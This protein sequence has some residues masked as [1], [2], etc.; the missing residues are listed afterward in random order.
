MKSKSILSVKNLKISF[1]SGKEENIAVDGVSF[2]LRKGEILGIVGES[3]SGKSLTS[4]SILGLTPPSGKLESTEII[5]DDLDIRTKLNDLNEKEF[6][7]IRGNR[8][9]MIFQEPSSSLNP[10]YT[11]GNQVREMFTTHKK[12]SRKEAKKRTLELFEKVNL[13]NS[14]KIYHSYPHE[15]SGGQMQ[16]VMI[17]MA[18]ACQPAILLAD[19]PTTALDVTI[20]KN[21]LELMDEMRKEMGTSIIF[22]SHDLGV[23]AEIADRVLVMYKGKIVE[24]G[25]IEEIFVRPQH[26]YTKGLL[27]CR[28]RLDV[29]L[30]VLPTIEDFMAENESEGGERKFR[31]VGEALILNAETKGELIQKR[32]DTIKGGPLIRIKKLKKYYPIKSGVFGKIK[33]FLKAVDSVSFD[34]YPGETIGLVGESGCGKTT[35]GKTI[36]KLVDSTDG[37][38]MYDGKVINHLSEGQLRPMRKDIQIIFQD[39]YSSLNPKHRIGYTILEPMKIH[40]ILKNDKERKERVYEL[41]EKVN[42]KPE[43]FERYPHQFSGG[44]RQRISIARALALNP[45]FI[46]CDESVS[47]LDVSIQAQVLNLLNQLKKEFNFTYLFISHDLSVIKF[48]ADRILVM[49]DG[50]LVEVG[51]SDALFERPKHEYTRQLINAIPK[52]DPEDI[53]KIQMRKKTTETR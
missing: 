35:L 25:T 23:I 17:A 26:P 5:F 39:P 2:Q 19:E 38:V 30:N 52:S 47:A 31:S 10:V 4:L 32:M 14:E 22:I 42:L 40:G 6:R 27:A 36:L 44:Q 12:I 9:S 34:I 18:M 28:P 3:G 20:Q 16:R 15:I 13:F 37:T 53:Y 48:I 50:K 8:I 24:E 29:K 46:V 7:K 33:G 51:Y 11:C 43:H 45:K 49:K 21:I 41:L 1:P